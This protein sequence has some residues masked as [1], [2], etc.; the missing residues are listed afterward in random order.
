MDYFFRDLFLL[1][2]LLE[3]LNVF[4]SLTANAH[5]TFIAN[6]FDGVIATGLEVLVAAEKAVCMVVL[7]NF[8]SFT[9]EMG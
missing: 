7:S 4:S 2:H 8:K 9:L 1:L 3:L 6:W 5:Q